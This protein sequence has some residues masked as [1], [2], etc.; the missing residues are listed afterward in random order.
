MLPGMEP[1]P[2]TTTIANAFTIGSNHIVGC[3]VRNG[4]ARTP[5]A[6]A[7]AAEIPITTAKM[8]SLGMPM[9]C[10]ATGSCEIARMAEPSRVRWMKSH[11]AAINT[12]PTPR[13]S[14]RAP[15]TS[16]PPIVNLVSIKAGTLRYSEPKVRNSTCSITS[17]TASVIIN[18]ANCDL[19]IGRISTRSTRMPNSATRAIAS[20]AAGSSGSFRCVVKK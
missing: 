16:T 15:P 20:K 8:R 17:A 6:A 13:A 1:R 12:V 7:N 9:Y 10:A 3:T 5:A 18:I 2:P 11:S 19:R 4:P 14:S